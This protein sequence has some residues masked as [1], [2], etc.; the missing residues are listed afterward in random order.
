VIPLF[1]GTAW[2]ATENLRSPFARSRSWCSHAPINIAGRVALVTEQTRDW[3]G[4]RRGLAAR[5]ADELV[6]FLRCTAQQSRPGQLTIADPS[7]LRPAPSAIHAILV[8]VMPI[9]LMRFDF[10][11]ALPC[12]PGV[13]GARLPVVLPRVGKAELCMPVEGRREVGFHGAYQPPR[14][15]GMAW[16]TKVNDHHYRDEW[17]GWGSFHQGGPDPGSWLGSINSAVLRVVA[18]DVTDGALEEIGLTVNRS[19]DDWYVAFRDWL[20]VLT[21][22]DLGHEHAVRTVSGRS[23]VETASWVAASR[24]SGERGYKLVNPPLTI[25]VQ[26]TPHVAR[27]EL[28]R[29]AREANLG[30]RPPEPLLLLRDARSAFHRKMYRRCILDAAIAVEVVTSAVLDQLLDQAVGEP[31]RKTLVLARDPISR[32][33]PIL[34][35]LGAPLP[36]NLDTVLFAVRNKVI[37]QGKQASRSEAQK[38]LEA[39]TAAVTPNLPI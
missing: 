35:S 38:A 6:I 13:L 30:H 32:K 14:L 17:M 4:D 10:P 34:R 8:G 18:P 24:I 7:A 36:A 1:Y 37:H 27:Q 16:F 15:R 33:I 19:L 23:D 25:Y 3:R 9:A 2:L 28:Q 20:E 21:H 31:A 29:A 5:S 39:A 12:V 22:V 11:T 26:S